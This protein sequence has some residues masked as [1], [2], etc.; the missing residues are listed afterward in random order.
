MIEY[1]SQ[2]FLRTFFYWLQEHQDIFALHKANLGL[3]WG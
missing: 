3:V 1:F 2:A